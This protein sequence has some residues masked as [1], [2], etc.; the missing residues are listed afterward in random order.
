MIDCTKTANY[1]AEKRRMTKKRKLYA[2]LY[3]CELDCSDCP[4]SSLNKVRFVRLEIC[5]DCYSALP[6]IARRYESGKGWL[7]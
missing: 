3:E 6:A 2:G 4:L 5:Y 7:D 1:F